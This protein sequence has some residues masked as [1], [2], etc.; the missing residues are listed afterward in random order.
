MVRSTR[1]IPRWVRL[2][3]LVVAILL[4]AGCYEEMSD[5]RVY[6]P[7][8]YKGAEDPLMEISGTEELHEE[9]AQRFQAV[10]TDR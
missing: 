10:Q 7:G 4:L 3:G 5:V 2:S 9:L 8:V 1:C 6:D